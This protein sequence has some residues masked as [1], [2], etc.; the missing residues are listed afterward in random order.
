MNLAGLM[1]QANMPQP[2]G[3]PGRVSASAT[4]Y[5]SQSAGGSISGSGD[6]SPAVFLLLVVGGALLLL[7]HGR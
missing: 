4:G 3:V 2:Q 7:H 6:G 1:P 5:V